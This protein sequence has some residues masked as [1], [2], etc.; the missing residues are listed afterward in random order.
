MAQTCLG[1]ISIRARQAS[2]VF[3]EGEALALC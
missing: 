2:A 3:V 1:S